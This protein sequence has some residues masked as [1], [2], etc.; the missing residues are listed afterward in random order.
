M[1]FEKFYALIKNQTKFIV[2]REYFLRVEAKYVIF[3][4]C[5]THSF[6]VFTHESHKEGSE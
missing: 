2:K 1:N 3:V 6:Y 5:Y 4:I